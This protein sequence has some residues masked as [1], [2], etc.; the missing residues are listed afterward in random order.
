MKTINLLAV[1]VISGLASGCASKVDTPSP[2]PSPQVQAPVKTSC[3]QVQA[4]VQKKGNFS[5][6]REHDAK[7][8]LAFSWKSEDDFSVKLA[9]RLT[10][11]IVLEKA[12]IVK[13]D[14]ADAFI[15]IAPE[16]E[17]K[18]KTGGY[19]R[20]SCSQVK[21]SVISNRKIFAMKVFEPKEMPR[22]LGAQ[23]AKNQY[24]NQTEKAIT[25]FLKKEL[26]KI[27]KEQIAVRKVDFALKN[28]QAKTDSL[29]VAKQIDKIVRILG[30][31]ANIIRFANIHQDNAR[32][33]CS[34][35]IVY[36]KEKF[37]QGIINYLNLKLAG[38]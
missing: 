9:D 34:F 3:P 36:L 6:V 1:A 2:Q 5:A 15:M 4:M 10:G 38:K 16:F 29:Y 11:N 8:R 30:A 26:E 12:D 22:K 19:Y 24:L 35:R 32:A 27:S 28:T 13:P 23:N 37:P 18:D 25:P 14:N 21:I 17:L 33:I 20:Y 7:L 31:D